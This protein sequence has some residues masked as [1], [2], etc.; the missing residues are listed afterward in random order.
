[1][2]VVTVPVLVPDPGDRINHAAVPLAVQARV[3]S[4]VFEIL[5]V[6]GAGLAPPTVPEKVRLLTLS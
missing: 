4:P 3:P 6:L 2:L 5:N 1:M